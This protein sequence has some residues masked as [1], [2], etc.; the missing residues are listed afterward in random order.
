MES[1][2]VEALG[3]LAKGVEDPDER[4]RLAD[5]VRGELEQL[6]RVAN[7]RGEKLRS[8]VEATT[9]GAPGRRRD[10]VVFPSPDL[11]TFTMHVAPYD[12]A[13]FEDRFSGPPEPTRF[14]LRPLPDERGDL[15]RGVPISCTLE[16]PDGDAEPGDLRI[17][18]MF[19]SA[20]RD[21]D[22]AVLVFERVGAVVVVG[23]PSPATKPLE[24][25]VTAKAVCDA[26]ALGRLRVNTQHRPDGIVVSFADVPPA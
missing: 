25:L 14:L 17:P 24:E 18:L 10:V 23:F 3:R 16:D 19:V 8:I 12:V 20:R 21:G 5:I 2:W 11:R 9:S 22:G 26:I 15:L 6:E 4:V 13:W 7:R 1:S